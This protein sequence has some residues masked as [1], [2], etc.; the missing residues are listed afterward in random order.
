MEI[1]KN[2]YNY[3]I[4]DIRSIEKYNDYHMPNAIHIYKDEL[5]N[6]PNKYLNKDKTYLLYCKEG[7]NSSI[8][9]NYLNSIGYS[10]YSILGGY[11][12]WIL[13]K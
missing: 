11:E 7:R 9:S 5:R 13:R 8:L 12:N 3:N 2:N 1:M 4:I 10:T 6:N